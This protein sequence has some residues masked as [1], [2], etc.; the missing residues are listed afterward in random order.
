MAQEPLAGRLVFKNALWRC[1]VSLNEAAEIRRGIRRAIHDAKEE[2]AVQR[3]FED[4]Q[5]A[6]LVGESLASCRLRIPARRNAWERGWLDADRK[7]AEYDLIR[8]MSEDEKA[9]KRQ[10]LSALKEMIGG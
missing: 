9:V 7:R 10:K 1:F 5:S 4:G 2:L 6:Q 3:A 8:N